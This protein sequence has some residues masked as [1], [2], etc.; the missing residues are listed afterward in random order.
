MTSEQPALPVQSVTPQ[1]VQPQMDAEV[2]AQQVQDTSFHDWEMEGATRQEA[3]SPAMET[4]E[5]AQPAARPEV[6]HMH[7]CA[8]VKCKGNC[9]ITAVQS[10]VNP[11]SG[12]RARQAHSKAVKQASLKKREIP[13]GSNGQALTPAQTTLARMLAKVRF[14]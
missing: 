11:R 1:N 9:C 14:P 13:D 7:W 3:R 2:R 5:S 10:G 6:T 8:A 4:E 12:E